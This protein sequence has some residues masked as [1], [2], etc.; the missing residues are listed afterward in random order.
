M[1]L[2]RGG[3]L[4]LDEIGDLS[5]LAQTKILRAIQEK[6]NIPHRRRSICRDRFSI[7]LCY[8]QRPQK[9]GRGREIPEDLYYRINV[10]TINLPPLRERSEDIDGFI[11]Y[12]RTEFEK[13]VRKTDS[14]VF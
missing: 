10:A 12:Y 5:L 13:E 3:T 11:G 7:D 1:E 2:A 14:C 4:F 9:T 8:E 6:G